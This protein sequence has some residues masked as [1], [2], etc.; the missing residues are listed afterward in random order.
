MV[1][2]KKDLLLELEELKPIIATSNSS[3]FLNDVITLL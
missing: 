1:Q 3:I 2:V